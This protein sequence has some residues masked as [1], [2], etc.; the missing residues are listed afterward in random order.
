MKFYDVKVSAI[1]GSSSTST[2]WPIPIPQ[3]PQWTL[4]FAYADSKEMMQSFQDAAG[5][6]VGGIAEPGFD[7]F[8]SVLEGAVLEL[9]AKFPEADVEILAGLTINTP[10]CQGHELL[11]LSRHGVHEV[12]E[13]EYLGIGDSS[14]I[15]YLGGVLLDQVKSAEE[16]LA[17]AVYMVAQ[18]KLYVDGCGGDTDVLVLEEKQH[19]HIFSRQEVEDVEKRLKPI[20]KEFGEAFKRRLA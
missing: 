8:R 13:W 12:E 11:K 18:A 3:V 20:G 14:L 2:E 16:K 7:E 15:R 4:G 6:G 1:S 19:P 9:Y 5:K 17:L 10:R